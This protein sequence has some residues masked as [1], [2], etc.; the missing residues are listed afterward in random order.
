MAYTTIDDPSAYFQ[1]NLHSGDGGTGQ[2]L[3]FDGNSDLQL[4]FHWGKCRSESGR[5]WQVIDTVRGITKGLTTTTSAAEYTNSTYVTAI[6]SNGYSIGQNND[7]N[8]AGETY[9]SYNWKGNSSGTSV[10][11]SGGVDGY[12]ACTHYANQDA[13]FSIVKYTG[14]NSV[15]N[16]GQDT[17]VTHGLGVIPKMIIIKSTDTVQNWVVFHHYNWNGCHFNLNTNSAMNCNL[18]VGNNN[19]TTSSYFNVGNNDLTNKNSAN[20]ISYVFAEKKGYSKFGHV[21]GN[22]SATN[23]TFC[24]TGFKPAWILVKN[25]AS[26]NWQ[27]LDN[28]RNLFNVAVN[29]LSPDV[30]DAEYTTETDIDFLSNGFKFYE[31]YNLNKTGD[32]Y[33][34]AAFAENPFVTSTGVPATAR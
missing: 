33:I 29:S 14:R 34:F 19:N 3:T 27:L 13:G 9:V 7:N 21:V 15:L 20:F 2:T 28:K 8:K 32:T 4:D 25:K 31:N 26:G 12:N 22:G 5:D 24:Y 11:A 17:R 23:G 10:S 16:N 6:G 18:Y 30:S 1:T